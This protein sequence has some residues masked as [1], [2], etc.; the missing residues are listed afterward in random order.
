MW[1]AGSLES[2]TGVA[3]AGGAAGGAEL[4][5]SN[6]NRGLSQAQDSAGVEMALQGCLRSS[7]ENWA[8]APAH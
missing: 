1:A 2:R 8:F 3:E 5:S 7:E 6:H 4:P